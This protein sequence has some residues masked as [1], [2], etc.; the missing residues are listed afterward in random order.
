MVIIQCVCV[1]V[2]VCVSVHV[3]VCVPSFSVLAVATFSLHTQESPDLLS[4]CKK[5]SPLNRH[6]LSSFSKVAKACSVPKKYVSKFYTQIG[7]K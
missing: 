5:S 3:S 4:C 6:L 2:C 1:C 7:I